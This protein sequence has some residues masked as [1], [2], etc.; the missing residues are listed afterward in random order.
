MYVYVE[1]KL[2][3]IHHHDTIGEFFNESVYT[4]HIIFYNKAA[5]NSTM[6]PVIMACDHSNWHTIHYF[7]MLTASQ[8]NT[9]SICTYLYREEY[10]FRCISWHY[11]YFSM[12]NVY[13]SI[14]WM[15]Y[16][17]LF[18]DFI[19]ILLFHDCFAFYSYMM[20]V[21]FTIPWFPCILV[22]A[23]CRIFRFL[24]HFFTIPWFSCT[25]YSPFWLDLAEGLV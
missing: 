10:C 4:H 12:M 11:F 17:L 23:G 25:L 18:P 9:Y 16:V 22:F 1:Y 8:T 21:Y 6:K 13:S 15:S 20:F 7:S 24:I 5:H 2:N 14:P 19:C 3:W